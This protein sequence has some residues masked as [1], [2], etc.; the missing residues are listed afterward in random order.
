MN[1]FKL[2]IMYQ[3]CQTIETA[4]V[5]NSR[6][7]ATEGQRFFDFLQWEALLGKNNSSAFFCLIVLK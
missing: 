7:W 3:F 4:E 2:A 5:L 1:C 6:Q